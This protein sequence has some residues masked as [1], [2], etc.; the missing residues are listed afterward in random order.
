MTYAVPGYNANSKK[1]VNRHELSVAG[2]G[3]Y[4]TPELFGELLRVAIEFGDAT[5]P[6]DVVIS[7]D[8]AIALL[9]ISQVA[10]PSD[11][12]PGGLDIGDGGSNHGFTP[13][14]VAGP[15]TVVVSSIGALTT[16]KISFYLRGVG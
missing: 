4:T 9:S 10:T 14:A 15:L 5:D 2:P 11:F 7:D 12:A 13:V 3:T 16:M 1:S 8:Y 6:A